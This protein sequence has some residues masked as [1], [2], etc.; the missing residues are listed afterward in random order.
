M[1]KTKKYEAGRTCLKCSRGPNRQEW[2]HD[3]SPCSK[4]FKGNSLM[5][6]EIHATNVNLF[7]I[8]LFIGHVEGV[9]ANALRGTVSGNRLEIDKLHWADSSHRWETLDLST[10]STSRV[11]CFTHRKPSQVLVH[12]GVGWSI[13]IG[14][15]GV[16]ANVHRFVEVRYICMLLISESSF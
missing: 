11:F 3:L 1:F 7:F 10:V 12:G 2:L 13:Y 16:M 8:C 15:V 5:F 9:V 6:L 4:S 14:V